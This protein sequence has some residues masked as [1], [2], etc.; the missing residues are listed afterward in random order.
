VGRCFVTDL[1]STCGVV[2]GDRKVDRVG[3]H[4][5]DRVHV[6]GTIFTVERRHA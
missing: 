5:G 4:E 1:Q 2:V 6:G 3:V